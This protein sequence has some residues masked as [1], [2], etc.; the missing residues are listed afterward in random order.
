MN[1]QVKRAHAFHALHV[2]GDPVVLFNVWD[3]GS[4]KAVAGAGAPAVA[5]GS[6][7]VAAANGFVDGEALPLE[8]AISNAARIA[9]AVD[10]PVSIDFEGGYAITEA[11]LKGNIA[12]L[13]ATGIV[14]INFE[15]G[16]IG[17]D[18]LYPIGV[19]TKR[20]AAIRAAADDES[21]PLFINARTDIFLQSEPREHANH[22][23]Q[24]IDRAAAYTDS[25]AHCLF[26]PGLR[27]DK[28]IGTLCRRSP[29]P[30]NLMVPP[31]PPRATLAA[32]GVARVSFGPEPFQLVMSSLTR[33]ARETMS[34]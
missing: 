34:T 12:R 23:Q 20:L 8:M 21:I 33:A 10:V 17:G 19:Q 14:G 16:V 3:P 6:W 13:L 32:L 5:T 1:E 27:D 2:P 9:A 30:V 25:G 29:L 18:G 31:A 15:D 24:A 4:A 11:G 22:L 28:L 7:S 26:V